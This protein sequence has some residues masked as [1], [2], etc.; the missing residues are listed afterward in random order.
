MRTVTLLKQQRIWNIQNR[1]DLRFTEREKVAHHRTDYQVTL[2]SAR[3]LSVLFFLL[4]AGFERAKSGHLIVCPHIFFFKRGDVLW[5]LFLILREWDD[6]AMM[7]FLVLI[8]LVF[9][10]VCLR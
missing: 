8:S 10:L 7:M 3:L 1:R 4:P 6:A 2:Y 9:L 5:E